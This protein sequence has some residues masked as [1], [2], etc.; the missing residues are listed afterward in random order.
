MSDYPQQPQWQPTNPPVPPVK[1]SWFARHKVLSVVLGIV[2]VVVLICCAAGVLGIGGDDSDSTASSETSSQ[3]STA[4]ESTEDS[5]DE[6]TGE[7]EEEPA[8]EEEPAE[9][10]PAEP[11]MSTE[12]ANAVRSAENY[13]EFMPFSKQ[14]LIDQLSS[15]A[16]DGYPQEVAVFAVEHIE[17]DVD[18]KE[19]AVK[20][21]ENYQELMGFSRDGL[22][23]QLT[24]EA[25]DQYTQ[26]QAEYAADQIG[27]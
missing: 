22:I 26:E 20:A 11:E 9:E 8:T 3:T 10:E 1:Q 23:Q 27:L 5:A 4:D 24:S 21:A 14:G 7:A 15:P 18:W 12:Q 16:G 2:L 17:D 13:L 25:G 6:T 19:Q